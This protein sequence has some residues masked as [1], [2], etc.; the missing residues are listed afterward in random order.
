M[1]KETGW[2]RLKW[3][4]ILSFSSLLLAYLIWGPKRVSV[5]ASQVVVG[6][7][8]ERMITD[9]FLRAKHRYTLTAPADGNMQRMPFK[10]GSTLKRGQVISRLNSNSEVELIRSPMTGV[11]SKVYRENAGPIRRGVPMIEI[12]DPGQIEVVT[13]PLTSEAMR[14]PIGACVRTASLENQGGCSGRVSRVGK[15]EH[16]KVSA[17]GVN[18]KRTEVIITLTPTPTLDRMLDRKVSQFGNQFHVDLDIL[19]SEADRV[20]KIPVGALVRSSDGWAV[21][22]IE[23]DHAKLARIQIAQRSASEVSVTGGL[24]DRDWVVIFP[25]DSLREGAR[26]RVNARSP[27]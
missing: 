16:V 7:L 19:I 15:A 5:E 20:L 1:R 6:R 10:V 26:L 12:V 4:L 27:K 23:E 9:G 8:E 17:L 22:K 3:L 25:G 13:T 14:I 2:S 18:E 11:V 21:Y 24:K